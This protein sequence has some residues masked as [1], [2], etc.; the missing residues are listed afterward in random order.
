MASDRVPLEQKPRDVLE[1]SQRAQFVMKQFMED[2]KNCP[3]RA[4]EPLVELRE[5]IDELLATFPPSA[6][7]RNL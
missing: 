4:W 1:L 3:E 2:Q 7:R 6:F 5:L